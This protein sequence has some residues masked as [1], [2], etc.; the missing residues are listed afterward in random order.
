MESVREWVELEIFLLNKAIPINKYSVFFQILK[1]V[2]VCE[3][4]MIVKGGY[5]K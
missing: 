4:E 5:L 2:Y 3:R 1:C